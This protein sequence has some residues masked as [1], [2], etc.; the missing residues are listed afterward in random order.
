MTFIYGA[1]IAVGGAFV[2]LKVAEA[3]RFGGWDMGV[4]RNRRVR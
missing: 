2:I 4:P 3:V 1:L